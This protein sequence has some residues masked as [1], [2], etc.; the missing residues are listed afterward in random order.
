MQVMTGLQ[1]YCTA[2]EESIPALLECALTDSDD[3]VKARAI[4][5]V[6]GILKRFEVSD[7]KVVDTITHIANDE[8]QHEDLRNAMKYYL[9]QM[10]N[11]MSGTNSSQK[12][13]GE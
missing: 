11:D 9:M 1:I 3:I 2:P 12:V 6:L 13:Q 7:S 10:Q 8:Q 4:R 5:S